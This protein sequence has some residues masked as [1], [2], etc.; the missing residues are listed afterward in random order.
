M[1]EAWEQMILRKERDRE[2]RE[3]DNDALP[4]DEDEGDEEQLEVQRC[5]DELKNKDLFEKGINYED[6]RKTMKERNKLIGVKYYNEQEQ[7]VHSLHCD[8]LLNLYRCEIKLGK[9][10][11]IVKTQTSKLLQT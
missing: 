11:Q 4:L 7:I 5:I 1:Y 6:W 8:L 2:R 9:E 3:R 10:M